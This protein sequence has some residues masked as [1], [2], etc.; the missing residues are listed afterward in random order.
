MLCYFWPQVT[1]DSEKRLRAALELWVWWKKGD[2][3]FICSSSPTLFWQPSS[4]SF[5]P[6]GGLLWTSVHF[7]G[8]DSLWHIKQHN[9]A[10]STQNSSCLKL[11]WNGC[12]YQ[13][14]LIQKKIPPQKYRKT[15][16]SHD[17]LTIWKS[18][19]LTEWTKQTSNWSMS[20]SD[21]LRW[22]GG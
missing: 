20:T 5:Q 15:D 12:H 21:D 19:H 18:D 9:L 7:C 1:I 17:H 4:L 14:W 11:Y 10:V 22:T 6:L 13:P 8:K 16:W 2:I 3:I